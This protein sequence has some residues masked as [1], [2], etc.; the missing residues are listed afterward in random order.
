[1]E[2]AGTD[3]VGGGGVLGDAMGRP[4]SYMGPDAAGTRVVWRPC[5]DGAAPEGQGPGLGA[6]GL[7][8]RCSRPPPTHTHTHTPTWKNSDPGLRG[9]RREP[10]CPL[11]GAAP[12][13]RPSAELQTLINLLC[14][15]LSLGPAAAS[16]PLSQGPRA[17]PEPGIKHR[18]RRGT[19]GLA[20]GGGAPGC[21]SPRCRPGPEVGSGAGELWPGSWGAGRGD[22]GTPGLGLWAKPW[23]GRG[24]R[25]PQCPAAGGRQAVTECRGPPVRPSRPPPG[26]GPS[27]PSPGRLGVRR[28]SCPLRPLSPWH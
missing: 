11:R 12:Q 1:M 18:E 20:G 7:E 9:R 2:A 4:D 15:H 14:S 3:A 24:K 28:P 6:A 26:P 10:T 23:L 21:L 5:E 25:Q 8:G 27:R 13:G 16:H 17:L 19:P 22:D